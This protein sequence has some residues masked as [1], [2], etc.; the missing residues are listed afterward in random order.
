MA[1][2]KKGGRPKGSKDLVPRKRRGADSA[3]DP[4]ENT[5]STKKTPRNKTLLL[6][7]LKKYNFDVVQEILWL[8]DQLK[9][10]Y[11]NFKLIEEGDNAEVEIKIYP[12][13]I[14]AQMLEILKLLV[15]HSFPKM[16]SLELAASH[17]NPITLNF[18]LS[19]TVEKEKPKEVKADTG[20]D[21]IDM[22]SGPAGIHL[23]VP[24]KDEDEEDEDGED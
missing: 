19:G 13:D 16:K 20:P 6:T 10:Q 15:S 5:N 2:K 24:I 21:A 22:I 1:K 8:Y 7:H 9:L 14:T 3:Q 12:K 23:P 17:D 18:N 4:W 11:H